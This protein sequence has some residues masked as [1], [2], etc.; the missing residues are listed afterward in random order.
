M[1]SPIH[2]F[3][4]CNMH[5]EGRGARPVAHDEPRLKG[6]QVVVLVKEEEARVV[7]EQRAHNHIAFQETRCLNTR[8][9]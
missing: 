3:M 1:R 2:D 7:G 8:T 6:E 9:A 4:G 5:S